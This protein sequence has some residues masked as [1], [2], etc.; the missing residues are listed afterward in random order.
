MPKKGKCECGE[1]GMER[2]LIVG[3]EI[4]LMT[5]CDKCYDDLQIANRV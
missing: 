2:M 4:K 1:I 3:N 5:L